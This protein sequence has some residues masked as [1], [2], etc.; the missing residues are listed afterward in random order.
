MTIIQ[1]IFLFKLA[2]LLSQLMQK[3]LKDYNKAS[4]YKKLGHC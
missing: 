4:N 3:A 2:E 1:R